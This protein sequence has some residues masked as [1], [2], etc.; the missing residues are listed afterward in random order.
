MLLFICRFAER[1]LSSS[2][3]FLKNKSP[4]LTFVTP[5][6]RV[7]TSSQVHSFQFSNMGGY[8]F[9]PHFRAEGGLFLTN[10]PQTAKDSLESA[11]GVNVLEK[12]SANKTVNYGGAHAALIYSPSVQVNNQINAEITK[13]I[14]KQKQHQDGFFINSGT[15]YDNRFTVA[16]LHILFQTIFPGTLYVHL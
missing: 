3:S 6:T 16:T 2:F 5:Y 8:Q 9:N 13:F 14:N 11:A 15:T 4:E 10:K 1:Q 7:Q 12:I